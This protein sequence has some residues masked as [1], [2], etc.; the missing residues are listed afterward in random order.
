MNAIFSTLNL[1]MCACAWKLDEA[2]V[3]NRAGDELQARREMIRFSIFVGI[4]ITIVGLSMGLYYF[5]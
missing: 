3:A 1:L 4:V 5:L 2:S